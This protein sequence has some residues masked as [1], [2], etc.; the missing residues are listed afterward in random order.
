MF[1][2]IFIGLIGI[3]VGCVLTIYHNWLV[4][5]VG[6][7]DWADKYLAAFGGARFF[8]I[9]L[10]IFVILLSTFYMTGNLGQIIAG[11]FSRLFGGAAI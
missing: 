8:Y 6:R 5:N 9:L 7:S 11:I 3:F 4:E 2:R 1:L 10:G